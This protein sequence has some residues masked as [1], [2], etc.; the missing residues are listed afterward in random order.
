MNIDYTHV[1]WIMQRDTI[2]VLTL[3]PTPDRIWHRIEATDPKGTRVAIDLSG[4]EAL[5]LYTLL[6]DHVAGADPEAAD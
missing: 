4:A 3:A 6:K 1:H 5:H 2:I